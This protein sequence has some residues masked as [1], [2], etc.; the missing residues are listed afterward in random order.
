MNK[1]LRIIISLGL[2]GFLG[3][4]TD[5]HQVA[6]AFSEMHIALWLAAVGLLVI[7]Q[8]LSSIRWHILAKDM[9][10][11]RPLSH[12]MGIYF[13]GTYFNL[14]LPTAVGGDVVRAWYLDG[15]SG[16]RLRAFLSVLLDRLCGLA[17]LLFLATCAV[18]L[19]PLELPQWLSL[20]VYALAGCAVLGLISLPIIRNHSDKAPGKLKH[21]LLALHELPS[22]NALFWPVV[23][24][25]AVQASNVIIVWMVGVSIGVE[26]PASFYWI[27]VPVVSLLTMLPISVNGMGVREGAM[28]LLLGPLG[29]NHGE[30]LTL[31]FL[32]FAV[33][34]SV[35]LLGGLVYL[36]GHFPSPAI[37][38]EVSDSIEEESNNG[39]FCCHSDQGRA[40]QSKAAA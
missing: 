30:A 3:W 9:Q 26:V 27:L 37:A 33:S 14:L 17:M 1:F 7:S 5:W 36:F 10:I 35:S 25:F 40:R 32:W 28:A 4:H 38:T 31:A 15:Q 23:L 18:L 24:S 29:V 20:S 21:L 19:S 8:L 12:M 16:Q 13:I 39:T 22:V 11:D 6:K 2:L 34:A